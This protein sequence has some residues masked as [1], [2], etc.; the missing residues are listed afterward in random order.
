MDYR[1]FIALLL[2]LASAQSFGQAY[3]WVDEDGVVHYSDRPQAGAEEIILPKAQSMQMVRR[4]PRPRESEPEE[5]TTGYD[6]IS[7][8][9]PAAEDTLWNIEGNLTVTVAL[10]PGL[11][12]GH[13][14]RLF[15]D[16]RERMFD[17]TNIE[18]TEIYRG[19][20]NLQA[21]IINESG[22]MVARSE[23]IRFYVQQTSVLSPP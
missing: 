10:E 9:S 1:L 5:P 8:A 13:Q 16:G 22:Q 11:R 6:S 19:A 7:I 4:A 18:L 15:V 20:H 3:R 12:Q 14:V 17:T 21:E 23:P 2:V